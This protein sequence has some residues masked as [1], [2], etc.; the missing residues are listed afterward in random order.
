MLLP[1]NWVR[2]ATGN[3][4]ISRQQV[5][6]EYLLDG[7]RSI[8]FHRR[9]YSSTACVKHVVCI[10]KFS[11]ASSL[12]WPS[13]IV[14]ALSLLSRHAS[15]DFW[16]CRVRSFFPELDSSFLLQLPA[17]PDI[18]GPANLWFRME[19]LCDGL[20][21]LWKDLSYGSMANLLLEKSIVLTASKLWRGWQCKLQGSRAL[22]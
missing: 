15:S 11:T 20:A 6:V 5:G 12:L 22:W 13:P 1:W 17:K 2:I 9:S 8:V 14:S 10:K 7:R 3:H 21:F 16:L 4:M 19:E 18:F